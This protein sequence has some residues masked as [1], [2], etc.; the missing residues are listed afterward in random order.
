MFIYRFKLQVLKELTEEKLKHENSAGD[1][2]QNEGLSDDSE[3]ERTRL[4]KE[5][6]IERQEK[7]QLETDIKK[8]TESLEEEKNRH[9][10][11]VLL[12]LAERNKIIV[13]YNEEKKRND[14]LTKIISEEKVNF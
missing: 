3:T 5:L 12:L 13:M 9:K 6:E 14:D 4:K 8:M 1:A 2:P 7:K 11:I 10:Q